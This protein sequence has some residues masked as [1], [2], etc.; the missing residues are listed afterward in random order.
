MLDRWILPTQPAL[1]FGGLAAQKVLNDDSDSESDN[2]QQDSGSESDTSM[3][4]DTASLGPDCSH[5]AF[6]NA[7]ATGDGKQVLGSIEL[8]QSQTGSWISDADFRNHSLLEEGAC[9][10]KTALQSHFR[11]GHA[12]L[13]RTVSCKRPVF[14][15]RF[16]RSG[17]TDKGSRMFRAR[18]TQPL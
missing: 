17:C 16:T 8:G 14:F 5:S 9:L 2:L 4:D 1:T 6:T 11:R 12:R 7:A 13:G 3:L 15:S 10:Q 18:R